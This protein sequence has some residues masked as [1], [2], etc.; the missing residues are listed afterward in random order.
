MPQTTTNP[1]PIIDTIHRTRQRMAEKFS[2]NITAILEDA[3]RRQE[4]S[5]RAGWREPPKSE[6]AS[7]GG[8]GTGSGTCVAALMAK[9]VGSAQRTLQNKTFST[10]DMPGAENPWHPETGGDRRGVS[11]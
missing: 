10:L 1:D 2:G 5:G 6:R 8:S 7:R 9:R 3:R 4:A 11:T